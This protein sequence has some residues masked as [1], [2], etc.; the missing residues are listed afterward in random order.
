[1]ITIVVRGNLCTL[2]VYNCTSIIVVDLQI[3]HLKDEPECDPIW[4]STLQG[5]FL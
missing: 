5:I 2:V 1:M 3:V 4:E